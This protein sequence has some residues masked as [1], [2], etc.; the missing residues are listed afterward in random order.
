MRSLR[1]VCAAVA[2][3]SGLLLGAGDAGAA[4]IFTAPL[5]IVSDAG[6]LIRCGVANPT[7]GSV[8]ITITIIDAGGTDL[9]T[10][11]ST[12]L[13]AGDSTQLSF[14]GV[15]GMVRCKVVTTSNLIRVSFNRSNTGGG[16]LADLNGYGQVK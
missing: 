8:N 4:N 2:L 1:S 14:T 3:V 7:N 12:T 5:F 6:D 16:E 15:N 11:V 10:T 13:A 9:A